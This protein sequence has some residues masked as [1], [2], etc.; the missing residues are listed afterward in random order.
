MLQYVH[1]LPSS[2]RSWKHLLLSK[3]LP[4]PRLLPWEDLQY[5]LQQ[6]ILRQWQGTNESIL[7]EAYQIVPDIPDVSGTFHPQTQND[8]SLLWSSFLLYRRKYH[9]LQY[10]PLL[11]AF[12]HDTDFFSLQHP[13]QLLPWNVES[14][15]PDRQQSAELPVQDNRQTQWLLLQLVSPLSAY[16]SYQIRWYLPLPQP[17][18]TSHPLR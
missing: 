1:C 12:L 7:Q 2:W 13:R 17:P 16:R 14:V 8:C 11:N 15:L 5:R 18:D 3:I 10:T 4:S 9:G 6:L